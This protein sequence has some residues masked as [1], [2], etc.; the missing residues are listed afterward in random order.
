MAAKVFHGAGQTGVQEIEEAH[1]LLSPHGREADRAAAAGLVAR[2]GP[3]LH[4]RRVQVEVV[5][6][7]RS[8]STPRS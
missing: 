2:I 5:R 8:S 7:H 1:A 4:D 6:H 3:G